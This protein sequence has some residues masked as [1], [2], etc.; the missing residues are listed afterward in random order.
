MSKFHFP[1]IVWKLSVSSGCH[2]EMRT[3]RWSRAS[4]WVSL[5][6]F[7]ADLKKQVAENIYIMGQRQSPEEKCHL[8][9]WSKHQVEDENILNGS[10]C[11]FRTTHLS[12]LSVVRLSLTSGFHI[13]FYSVHCGYT[14]LH[15]DPKFS[16][17][18]A[19]HSAENVPFILHIFELI[20]TY[21]LELSVG[22]DSYSKL[23]KIF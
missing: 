21:S 23:F 2:E 11:Y 12:S 9:W 1:K 7:Q 20:P 13:S 14:K 4:Q 22:I 18:F 10:W 6:F 15:V 19:V 5:R 17:V 16:F 8:P 3:L